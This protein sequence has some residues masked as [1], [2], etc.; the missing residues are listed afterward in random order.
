MIAPFKETRDE[1]Q[2]IAD[3]SFIYLSG[4]RKSTSTFPYEFE[5]D[6]H[7]YAKDDPKKNSM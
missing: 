5:E 7:Y 4:G 6:K 1:I 3:C 2:R